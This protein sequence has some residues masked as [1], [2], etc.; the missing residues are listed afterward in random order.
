M[1]KQVIARNLNASKSKTTARKP[2]APA[3][4]T[5]LAKSDISVQSSVLSLARQLHN[6]TESAL[7]MAGTL[8]DLSLFVVKSTVKKPAQKAALEKA[9]S[10]L[11]ELRHA[12]GL[13]LGE[14]GAA[15][16][17]KDPSFLGLVESGKAVLPFE[18]ILRLTSILGRNDPLGFILQLTRSYNPDLW[19]T[20][21]SLGIGKLIVQA[22]R[23]REFANVYRMHD[24][25]RDLNDQQFAASLAF[26]TAAFQSAMAFQDASKN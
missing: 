11:G 15:L 26:V 22:G 9:G 6:W 5:T 25:A 2:A 21:E 4:A 10:L 13:S 1:V 24:A 12:A 16:D 18:M 14:L 7:G 8:T 23:E 19:V 20:L 3:A 17:L